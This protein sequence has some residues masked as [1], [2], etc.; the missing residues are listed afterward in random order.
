MGS[1]AYTSLGTEIPAAPLL[2]VQLAT[3][4]DNPPIALGCTAFLDSGADCTLVPFEFLIRVKATIAGARE[5]VSGTAKGSTVVVPYFVGLKFDRFVLKVVRVRGC[6]S[7]DLGG[8][9]LIGRDLL[10]LFVLELNGPG[11][12]YTIF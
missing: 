7:E 2:Q 8:V 10:N 11:L 1:Y 9:I 3:P 4:G 12:T 5:T 6:S